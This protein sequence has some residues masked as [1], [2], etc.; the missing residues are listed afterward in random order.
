[1]KTMLSVRDAPVHGKRVLVRVDYNVPLRN[2]RV[3]DVN[4][5]VSSLPTILLLLR[6]KAKVILL[7]HLGRPGGR[8]DPRTS[9]RPAARALQKMLPRVKVSFVPACIGKAAETSVE[10]MKPGEL[11]LLENVRFHAEEER[12]DARFAARLARLAD[13]YVNDA[14]AASHRSHTSLDAITRLLPGAAGL[15]LEKEVRLLSTILKPRRPFVCIFGGA[16]I[17]DKIVTMEYLA[18]K[19]DV[20]LIGGALANSFLCASG[21]E[22]GRSLTDSLAAAER[23][24]KRYRRKIVLPSDAVVASSAKGK[25]RVVA[26]DAIPLQSRVMDIGPAT[27]KRFCRELEAAR[28]VFWNGPLGVCEVARFARATRAVAWFLARAHARTIIGGGDSAEAVLRLGLVSRFIHISTGGGAS[29]EFLAG[30]TMPALAALER[31]Y[32][33]FTKRG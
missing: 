24:L 18:R 9:L 28:T 29:L 22:V 26:V 14:F 15:L 27:V 7:S 31:N 4:R 32:A 2:G 8:R 16:K 20:L 12:N 23:I 17:S 1:M 11:L 3:A 5:I 25:S 13:W 33:R 30:R 21:I 6:R 19:A 10:R